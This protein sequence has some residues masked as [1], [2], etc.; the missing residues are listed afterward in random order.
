MRQKILAS[1]KICKWSL[2]SLADDAD[3]EFMEDV[4]FKEA[5]PFEVKEVTSVLQ[6]LSS[7]ES[8]GGEKMVLKLKMPFQVLLQSLGKMQKFQKRG[9]NRLQV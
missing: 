6:R 8:R 2:A 3:E 9:G 1:W 5:E 4:I 7:I